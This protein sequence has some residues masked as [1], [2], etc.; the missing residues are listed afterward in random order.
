[1]QWPFFSSNYKL[2]PFFCLK[3]QSLRIISNVFLPI[4]SYQ[5]TYVS[6]QK[7]LM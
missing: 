3:A 1:M 7:G 2:L 5:N 4:S 6:T